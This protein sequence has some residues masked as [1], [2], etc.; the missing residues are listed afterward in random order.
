MNSVVDEPQ[1]I[2]IET[3]N[4]MGDRI[5]DAW[6][7]MRTSTRRLINEK[8]DE[9]RLLFYVLLSDMIFFLSW[10]L[11]TAVSPIS[12]VEERIPVE[13]AF[14]LISALMFRTFTMYLF[15]GILAGGSRLFGGKGSW[16]DTRCGVFWGALVAAPFGFLMA[17]LTVMLGWLQPY[18][19]VLASEWIALPP[20]WIS[21]VPFI[22]F[23]SQGLAEAQGFKHNSIPF[24]VMSLIALAGLVGVIYLG[25]NGVL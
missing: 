7:D 15:S 22:W 6:R 19:P 5:L 13:I 4:N 2:L 12:G 17:V 20:Y 25:A 14:W 18:F 1:P 3:R 10:A 8:P 21:L 23:I 11:K 9:H 16:K 24:M